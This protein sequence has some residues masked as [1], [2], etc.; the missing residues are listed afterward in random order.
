LDSAAER[1]NKLWPRRAPVVGWWTRSIPLPPLPRWW[2]FPSPRFLPFFPG[3]PSPHF[4]FYFFPFWVIDSMWLYTCTA[5]AAWKAKGR[6]M[7]F[8]F[9]QRFL[10]FDGFLFVFGQRFFNSMVSYL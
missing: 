3:P 2:C 5:A 1:R 4:P 8:L 6:W 9:G 10:K 7:V